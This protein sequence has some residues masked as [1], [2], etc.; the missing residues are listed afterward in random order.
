MSSEDGDGADDGAIGL[1]G[2]GRGPL[3][4]LGLLGDRPPPNDAAADR[5]GVMASVRGPPAIEWPALLADVRATVV[6]ALEG[7]PRAPLSGVSA[8]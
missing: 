7:A 4:L 8:A 3:G 6:E 1:R 5:V 2:E